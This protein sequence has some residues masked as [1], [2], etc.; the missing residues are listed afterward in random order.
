M[1]SWFGG[2]G[3]GD[4][5]ADSKDTGMTCHYV[6]M[7]LEMKATSDEVKKAY[8]KLALRYHPDRN[9]DHQ[10]AAELKFKELSAAYSVLSDPQ[11]RRW[12]DDHRESILRGSDGTEDEDGVCSSSLWRFFNSSCYSGDDGESGFYGVYGAA[13]S[14]ISKEEGPTAQSKPAPEFGTSADPIS[15]VI[16]F[17][18]YWENF[19]TKLTFAWADV[20]KTLDAPNR[21][22][23]RLMEKDNTKARDAARREYTNQV[24]SLSSFVKKR[25][26]RYIAYDV[27]TKRRKKEEEELKVALKLEETQARKERRSELQAQHANDQGEQEKRTEERQRAFLLADDSSESDDDERFMQARSA[28]G[29]DESSEEETLTKGVAAMGID[30]SGEKGPAAV[31]SP[32]D[33][34]T[35]ACEV[36]G[37]DFKLEGQLTQHLASKVHRKK[38][39]DLEKSKKKKGASTTISMPEVAV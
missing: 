1:A 24:R 11:E 26:P 16:A 34:A 7:E 12:Y 23:K 22:T 19:A 15:I 5:A 32:E 8:R 20:Y 25:D 38:V 3:A 33:A 39:Q 27:E 9:F 17:Y 2:E 29:G 30:N 18:Y 14:E 6:V 31:V 37:K 10:A 36:C 4:G 21:A 28:R 13:F 35:Y